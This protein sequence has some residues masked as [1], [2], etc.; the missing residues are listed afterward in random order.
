[1][2]V[3]ISATSSVQRL[4]LRRLRRR[5]VVLRADDSVV[6][7]GTCAHVYDG[8]AICLP[9]GTKANTHSAEGADASDALHLARRQR[10]WSK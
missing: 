10:C 1:M 3:C 6:C 9:S 7:A 2:L 5:L 4:R 8:G